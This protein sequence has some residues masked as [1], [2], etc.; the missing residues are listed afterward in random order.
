MK[1]PECQEEMR[2][3]T[4]KACEFGTHPDATGFTVDLWVCDDCEISVED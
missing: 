2:R 4:V 3:E 1:C